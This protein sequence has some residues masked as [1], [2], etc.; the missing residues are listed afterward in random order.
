MLGKY[1]AV[2]AAV[3]VV[4]VMAGLIHAFVERPFAPR[5]RRTLTIGFSSLRERDELDQPSLAVHHADSRT[6]KDTPAE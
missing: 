1:G 5:L 4:L 6:G 3:I 2:A